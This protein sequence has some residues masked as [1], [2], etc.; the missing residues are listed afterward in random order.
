MTTNM[1][2]RLR[3]LAPPNVQHIPEELEATGG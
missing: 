1:R 3:V 2:A